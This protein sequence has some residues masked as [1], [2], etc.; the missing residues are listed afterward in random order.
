MKDKA[1]VGFASAT[2]CN[3]ADDETREFRPLTGLKCSPK[4]HGL[5]LASGFDD[6]NMDNEKG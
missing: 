2:G 5:V 6:A 3:R 1:R 4:R